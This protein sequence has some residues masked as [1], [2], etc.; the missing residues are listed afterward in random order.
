MKKIFLILAVACFTALASGCA[1]Q[2]T[3]QAMTV[4]PGGLS[5]NP[6]AELRGRITVTDVSGGKETNPLWVSQVGN[7]EFRKALEQSLAL[8][9]FLAKSGTPQ[10]SLSAELV[11]L[12]QPVIGLT[13]DVTSVVNYKLHRDNTIEQIPITATGSASFSDSWVGSE[14]MRIAN[15]RSI[16]KNIE[17]LIRKLASN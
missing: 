11:S 14:R 7:L 8:S 10:L 2:A 1:T 12:D 15:E 3:S 17:E 9:G 4:L 16:K 5:A 13:F 6:N